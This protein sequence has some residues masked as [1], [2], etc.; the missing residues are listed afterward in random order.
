MTHDPETPTAESDGSQSPA[1]GRSM[2]SVPADVA[3]HFAEVA[4]MV[5]AELPLADGRDACARLQ[6]EVSEYDERVHGD[7]L[8]AA[9]GY[10]AAFNTRPAFRPPLD[11]LI[12]LYARRRSVSNLSKLYDALARAAPTER[13]R[14]GALALKAELLDD[15]KSDHAAARELFELA[16]A[17]DPSSRVAWMGLERIALRDGDG[18]LLTRAVGQLA[19][20]T[21]DA[22]RRA[23]LLAELAAERAQENTPEGLDEAAR[24]LR[25]AAALTGGRWRSFLDLERFGERTGRVADVV[26]ALEGRAAL[27]ESF[28]ATGVF[29]GGS[30]AF[31]VPRVDTTES[32][33]AE[34]A[35]LWWRAARLRLAALGDADGSREAQRRFLSLSPDDARYHYFAMVL[36]DQAHEIERASAEAGWLL[37]R[38]FGDASLRASM[39]FRIAETAALAGDLTV[40]AAALREAL[41]LNPESAAARGALVEQLVA[42]GD[43]AAVVREFDALAEATSDAPTRGFLHRASALYALALTRDLPAAVRSL[44]LACEDDPADTVSRRCLIALLAR[45]SSLGDSPDPTVLIAQID[46]LLPQVMDEDERAALLLQR[47]DAE[48]Y[49]LRDPRAA[50]M[51]AEHLV[52]VSHASRWAVES[53]AL[54]WAAAHEMGNAARWALALA[55]LAGEPGESLAWRSAAA[56]WSWAAGDRDRALEI[57]LAGHRAH[58]EDL[59]LSAL[60]FRL[61]LAKRDRGTALDVAVQSADAAGLHLGVPWL[62]IAAEA[63]LEQGADDAARAALDA[64]IAR[65]AAE[66]LVRAAALARTRWRGDAGARARVAQ[67]AVAADAPGA[68]AVALGVELAL[69][70][71]FV[72]HDA[73]AGGEIVERLAGLD[74]VTEPVV[75]LLHAI[76]RG[77]LEGPD[78][79]ATVDA[80][81][82]V[83]H[84]LPTTDRL[85]VGIELEIAR[86][87]G[88]STA[89]RDQAAAARELVDEDRPHLAAPRLLSLLD[90]IEREGREDVPVALGRVADIADEGTAEALRGAA[91]A[92]LRAQ[93]RTLDART[94]AL[95]YPGLRASVAVLSESPAGLDRAGEYAEALALRETQATAVLRMDLARATVNWTSL[96]GQGGDALAR[97]RRLLADAPGDLVGLD[98]QRVA[99]RREGDLAAVADAC[100]ALAQRVKSP[101]R[102]GGYWEEAGVVASDTLGDPERAERCLRAALDVAPTR[103][104]AYRKLREILEE[105]RDNAGLESLVT[106]RLVAVPE[107]HERTALYWEQARLRRALGRREDALES[108]TR[109]AAADP[110]HAA[111][112]A[113]VAEV[114]AASGRLSELAEA[115]VAL[116]ACDE[117]PCAQRRAARLGAIELFDA[118]LKRPARAVEQLEALVRAGDADDALIERGI[119]IAT[120]AELWDAVLRLVRRAAERAPEGNARATA[121]L[122]VAHVYR[123]RLRD[124]ASAREHALAAHEEFPGDLGVLGTL[125]GLSDP[126]DRPRHARRALEA[127]REFARTAALTSGVALSVAEAAR[128]GGDGV[129]ERAALRLA[130]TLGDRAVPEP[131]A[132]GAPIGASLRDPA[133]VLRYRNPAD[134]GRAVALLEAVLPDLVELSGLTL[135]GLGVGRAERQRG[136]TPIKT[137][138]APYLTAAGYTDFEVYVGGTDARR[139]AVV[140]GDPPAVV[141]GR[142]VDVVHVDA[143]RFAFVR[144]LLLT[145]RGVAPLAVEAVEVTAAQ[146]MAALAAADLP[147]AGGTARFDAHLRPVARALSRKVRRAVAEIGRTVASDVDGWG[148]VVKAARVILSTARRGAMAVTGAMPAAFEDLAR[149]ES[150]ADVPTWEQVV[151]EGSAR[152]LGLFAISDAFAQIARETGVDQR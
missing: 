86:A 43:G 89:T 110:H 144:V 3:E 78:A 74:G 99:A 145:A 34:A 5:A 118:R 58:P 136:T 51:T 22:T 33:R 17:R 90:A 24:V 10:L 122:R 151:R 53:A 37:A 101:E 28:A 18:E 48:R 88:A 105:R 87:L 103:D 50:A 61:A 125:Q 19:A 70:R 93:G 11:A 45:G 116:A 35:W 131:P 71:A 31:A 67:A 16:V 146:V 134:S 120:R 98:V 77:A 4:R 69:V 7:E 130:R 139:I 68:E 29:E 150:L 82:R 72:D 121:M 100:E 83:L 55:D 40:S 64:A 119:E 106:Q 8:S 148:E 15:R 6:Y 75:T 26:Y 147:V 102:S 9:K 114:H 32:A 138:L 84:V 104:V 117:T 20:V 142:G 115:L 12:R 92:A 66:P 46:A 38:G 23:R 25:E 21:S 141:L 97:A 36:A 152:E 140:P 27:A 47:F 39:H 81:Q 123:D 94:L 60:T 109:V 73:Q 143:D 52:E 149:V 1:A 42:T 124:P 41:A 132:V 79:A 133:L 112:L 129:L 57:A 2:F 80:L 128:S 30:G 96:T 63:L 108:A 59:Y 127:L 65:A 14:A 76:V 13:D 91:I 113:M 137:A 54:L 111:A 44:R 126:D 62:V 107:G 49:A 135:D 95:Q 85:R 56:R